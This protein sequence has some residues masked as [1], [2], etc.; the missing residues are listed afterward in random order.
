[1][2]PTAPLFSIV[3]PVY[4]TPLD[5]L[6]TMVRSVLDQTF[7]DWELILVDD[8]GWSDAGCLGSDLYQTPNIDALAAGAGALLAAR[9]INRKLNAYDFRNKVVLILGHLGLW[10]AQKVKLY[11]HDLS[12]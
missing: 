4:N 6:E 2:S 5:V 11:R 7:A 1:M 3:T 10:A 8:W 9:A 12:P